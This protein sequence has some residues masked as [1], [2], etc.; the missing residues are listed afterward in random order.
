MSW[1]VHAATSL[2]AL[3]LQRLSLV[4]ANIKYAI[5]SD[6]QKELEQLDVKLLKQ[7]RANRAF[8]AVAESEAE[9]E[10]ELADDMRLV[11]SLLATITALATR[12]RIG[13]VL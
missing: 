6:K 11:E 2:A 3:C 5:V 7:S 10:P 4:L 9:L 12:M 13:Y 1:L 8:E